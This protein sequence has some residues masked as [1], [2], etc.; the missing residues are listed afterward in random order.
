MLRVVSRAVALRFD[1]R[2]KSRRRG[3]G[4]TGAKL[5]AFLKALRRDSR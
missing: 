5:I 4:S 2:G 1:N 3:A